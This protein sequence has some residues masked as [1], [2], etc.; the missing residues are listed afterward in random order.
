[1]ERLRPARFR[2]RPDEGA[3]PEGLVTRGDRGAHAGGPAGLRPGTRRAPSREALLGGG[4]RG[5]PVQ[6]LEVQRAA[7]LRAAGVGGEHGL[8]A[9]AAVPEIRPGAAPVDT[10]RVAGGPGR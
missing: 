10:V 3:G 1:M 7:D 6:T 9:P 8:S 2:A 4:C 5:L